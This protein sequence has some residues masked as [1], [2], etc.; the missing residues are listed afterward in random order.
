VAKDK[1]MKYLGTDRHGFRYYLKGD[2][3]WQRY[4]ELDIFRNGENMRNKWNGWFCSYPAWVRTLHK[5]VQG[6]T[7][8]PS[9]DNA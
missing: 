6:E 5:I 8:C 2:H 7:S 3:V 4:P 1:A 9:S